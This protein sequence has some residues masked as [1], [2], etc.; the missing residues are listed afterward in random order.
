MAGTK[1]KDKW[2]LKEKQK[3]IKGLPKRP[4][5]DDYLEELEL[6]REEILRQEAVLKE[7]TAVEAVEKDS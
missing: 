2:E 1:H 5:T 3:V 6:E 4:R 7:L